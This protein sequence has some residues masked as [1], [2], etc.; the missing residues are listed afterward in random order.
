MDRD[1][2][3]PR[4]CKIRCDLVNEH[5]IISL[6]IRKSIWN[7]QYLTFRLINV[8]IPHGLT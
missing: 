1:T 4:G 7:C 8:T 2:G 6:P 3:S 5:N